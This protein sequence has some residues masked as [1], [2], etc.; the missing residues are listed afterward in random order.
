MTF[1]PG[2][3]TS[4]DL[5]GALTAAAARRDEQ[6]GYAQQRRS[7]A[8]KPPGPA[9][10]AGSTPYPPFRPGGPPPGVPASAKA[11]HAVAKAAWES[12]AA[13]EHRIAAQA[14][15]AA[16]QV[17]P[18]AANV[19]HRGLR[20]PPR[21]GASSAALRSPPR[22]P[23]PPAHEAEW[24]R[25][26]E[27]QVSRLPGALLRSPTD[28]IF[29]FSP[30]HLAAGPASAPPSQQRQLPRH[31]ARIDISGAPESHMKRSP[32]SMHKQPP[33]APAAGAPGGNGKAVPPQIFDLMRA[34]LRDDLLGEARTMFV[35]ESDRE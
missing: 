28:A 9:D 10:H 26:A 34:H 21:S 8:S 32:S 23:P 6:P 35:L 33:S 27:M 31:T 30:Q 16:L 18:A 11:P 7:R 13:Y 14:R 3:E 4:D 29:F 22:G 20:S 5:S 15:A 25:D 24:R 1:T 12:D 2:I 19:R 17:P